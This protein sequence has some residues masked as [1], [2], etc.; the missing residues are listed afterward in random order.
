MIPLHTFICG[1]DT[2]NRPKSR[3]GV[4]VPDGSVGVAGSDSCTWK[5]LVFCIGLEM[6]RREERMVRALCYHAI[7]ASVII[8]AIG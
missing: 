8:W 4:S 6:G 3:I 7:I 1:D 2:P 5:Q